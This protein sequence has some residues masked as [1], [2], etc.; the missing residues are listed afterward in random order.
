MS[1]NDG[2]EENVKSHSER[3]ILEGC[4]TLMR[5]MCEEIQELLADGY[6]PEEIF[7]NE[8]LPSCYRYYYRFDITLEEIVYELFLSHTMHSGMTSRL[9]KLREL[10]FDPDAETQFVID[11]RESDE[12]C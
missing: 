8:N 12:G 2:L 3:R 11:V 4:I 1:K 6:T 5:R 9:K 7:E 10:G